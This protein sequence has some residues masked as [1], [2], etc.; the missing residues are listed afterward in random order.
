MIS[1]ECNSMIPLQ[2]PL[3]NAMGSLGKVA[4]NL[5]N[6]AIDL[7]GQAKK[8][9]L[10]G[11][12]DLYDQLMTQFDTAMDLYNSFVETIYDLF[13]LI[14]PYPLSVSNSPTGS[15]ECLT[16]MLEQKGRAIVTEYSSFL[17]QKF[18]GL[19]NTVLPIS[20]EVPVPFFGS[21]DIV[22]L[23]TDPEY[24]SILKSQIA[25]DL[26]G[27][28]SAIH[29]AIAQQYNGIMGMFSADFAV[30]EVWQW[31]MQQISTGGVSLLYDAMTALI[32]E[33]KSV[34]DTFGFPSLP[35]LLTLDIE[36]LIL[37]AVES[38]KSLYDS[39]ILSPIQSA[40]DQ[41]KSLYS[42][43]DMSKDD[44]RAAGEALKNAVKN[45]WQY[46]I[47]QVLDIGVFGVT[48]GDMVNIDTSLA[49]VSSEDT[50]TKLISQAKDWAMKFPL[51]ILTD[52]MD[53]VKDF[54]SAIG[55]GS[56]VV[57]ITFNFC[58]FLELIGFPLN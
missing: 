58:Q 26:S 6:T 18:L 47:N 30:Q 28:L 17:I 3:S 50:L 44:L 13:D 33:F 51:K 42:S 56:L 27:A 38:A 23:F 46:I 54:F 36:S 5:K 16:T 34:W 32:D 1:I 25:S 35:A 2:D 10:D 11:A 49:T 14:S 21:V 53:I 55:L 8:A 37:S 15:I 57:F 22:A 41:A 48:I 29:S 12:T 31:F 39:T 7:L 40:Y 52:W 9:L 19:I 43:G 45:K 24:A 4:A 20:F